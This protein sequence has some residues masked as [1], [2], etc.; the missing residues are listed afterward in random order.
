MVR[1]GIH[2]LQHHSDLMQLCEAPIV[3]KRKG[4]NIESEKKAEYIIELRTTIIAIKMLLIK[5]N[6]LDFLQL[7][8]HTALDG[9]VLIDPSKFY[10]LRS[11]TEDEV[12]HPYE[13][14]THEK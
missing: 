5:R 14:Q 7:L 10:V 9:H 13:K 6:N 8:A 2:P 12:I 11:L 4:R 1:F 3:H